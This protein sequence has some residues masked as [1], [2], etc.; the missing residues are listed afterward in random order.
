MI[1]MNQLQNYI[2]I[3]KYS[4]WLNEALRRESWKE[5]VARYINFWLDRGDISKSRADILRKAIVDMEVMPSMR[6]LMTAGKA[7]ERDHMA[8]F[9]CTGTAVNHPAVFAEAFY[10]LL[11]GSGFGFSVERQYIQK[12]PEVAEEIYESDSTIVVRDSK[13]GWASALKELISNLFNGTLPKW[14]TTKVRPAGARLKTFGGRASGPEPLE[15]L[16]SQVVRLFQHARGRALTSVECHDLLCFIADAV[17]VGGVRRSALISLSNLTDDRM[18]RAKDGQWWITS[19]Q[20]ALA[21]NSTAYTEKPDLDAFSKEW[22]TLYKS[23][24]GERGIFNKEYADRKCKSLGRGL[25]YTGSYVAN[26]CCEILL[27]DTGECCNLSSVVIRPDTTLAEMER[28]VEL[29]AVLGTLQSSLTEFRFVRKVWKTNC[30]EERLL[31]VSL[32]GIM[33]HRVF[34]GLSDDNEVIKW[35]GGAFHTLSQV[36]EHLKEKAHKVNKKW[37]K[38]LG[39][40]PATAITCIKPEGT[41]SLLVNCSSGIHTR[42]G[43]Y[44]MRRVRQ[45]VKDPLTRLM[46]DQGVPYVIEGDKYVFTFFTKASET[47]RLQENVGA[48]EQL[49]LWKIYQASWSDHNVSQTIYYTD[50]EYFAVADWVWQNWD[51]VCGLSFF[52]MD[53]N[54]YENAPIEVITQAQYNEGISNFPT[55][56]FSKLSEYEEEDNTSVNELGI[57]CSSGQCDMIQ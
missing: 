51:M 57:A 47:T 14:D 33:D 4:K 55:I 44:L 54:V 48:I 39:I 17:I 35:S 16:F 21:N 2:H 12:L 52:P 10:I 50:D 53:D 42:L 46:V 19:P 30:E 28:K 24:S 27:R 29:A 23:K 22:R 56:D 5:T 20:R 43:E 15:K 38:R 26:P 9:N 13:M 45:D 25:K 32:N 36:L 37:A 18:R 1:E 31:G 34:N 7:L 11:C 40:N 6:S 41:S 3:S 8:G 49:E